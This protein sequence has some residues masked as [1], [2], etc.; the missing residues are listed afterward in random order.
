MT[1]LAWRACLALLMWGALLA[2]VSSP[3]EAQ[4][5][6]DLRQLQRDLGDLRSREKD[7]RDQNRGILAPSSD[8]C[9]LCDIPRELRRRSVEG[10]PDPLARRRQ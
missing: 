6:N 4:S 3:A 7:L 1:D 9:F 10:T 2:F 8:G 5:A